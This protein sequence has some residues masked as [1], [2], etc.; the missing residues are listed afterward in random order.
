MAAQLGGLFAQ[1]NNAL[2]QHPLNQ[3]FDFSVPGEPVR[4][5]DTMHPLLQM[6]AQ[7]IGSAMGIDKDALATSQQSVKERQETHRKAL[8]ERAKS[9]GLDEV[10]KG[11]E[12]GGSVKDYLPQIMAE[13]QSLKATETAAV[14]W[15]RKQQMED[16]KWK[17]QLAM[18][19][20]KQKHA[21]EKEYAKWQMKSQERGTTSFNGQVW[22]TDGHGN[23]IA[24]LGKT[25]GEMGRVEDARKDAAEAELKKLKDLKTAG[26][27]SADVQAN[28]EEVLTLKEKLVFGSG[29]AAKAASLNPASDAAALDKSIRSLQSKLGLLVMTELKAMSATGATGFGSLSERELELLLNALT[30]L[31]VGM[32]DAN[33]ERN[34]QTVARYAKPF[35]D[36]YEAEY[37]SR[38][39]G[40]MDPT[41]EPR[42]ETQGEP[43]YEYR[44][45]NGKTQ[46]RRIK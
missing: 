26:E 6:G 28:V 25:E 12:A 19:D 14:E 31:D 11:L 8:V 30:P 2:L 32:D 39:K 46:R 17:R 38:P 44:T 20:V 40:A 10:A 42:G 3:S 29:L 21:I 9:L 1:L 24:P 35:L 22:M 34:L 18:A 15:K 13:E 16:L 27:K 45:V 41:R 33:L 43:E 23:P 36:A 37:G 4:P 7:G 5:T